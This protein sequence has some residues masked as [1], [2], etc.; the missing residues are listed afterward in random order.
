MYTQE[1]N[2]DDVNVNDTKQTIHDYIG[3]LAF[4]PNEPTAMHP[5]ELSTKGQR[6]D[7]QRMTATTIIVLHQLKL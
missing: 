4:T 3:S 1:A 2:D 7:E 6:E 5:A